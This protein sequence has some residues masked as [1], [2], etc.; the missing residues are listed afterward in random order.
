MTTKS[1]YKSRA[2][3]EKVMAL[4]DQVLSQWPV[5][6]EQIHVPTRHGD[7]FVVA[8]GK[9]AAPPMVLLHGS[10]SNSATWA[11]DVIEYSE[12]YRVYAVDI[13]GEP[14]KSAENRFSWDGPAFTEWLADVL[15][16]LGVD[17][18]ILVG[19]SLGGWAA[20]KYAIDQPDRVEE[21][22]LICPSG[23]HPPR[24]SFVVRAV[25]FSLLGDWGLNRMKRFV[26]QDAA[27]S[28]E[29][30]LFFTLVAKHFRYR[31]GAP[32]LFGDEELARLTMPVLFLAGEKDVLLDSQ[33]S[34]ERLQKTAPDVTVVLFQEDG[35]ATINKASQVV[36]FLNGAQDPVE[37]C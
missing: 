28:E 27:L 36:S 10:G 29:A 24:L 7:T 2:G 25:G 13:L 35:H 33:K 16:G 1:I 15:D 18:V 14:G 19:M 30:D 31:A 34:A 23:I 5:P 6:C 12:H 17:R 37:C 26:F 32:R 3:K 22:I 8:S 4:Y 9:A 11:H 20:M 21:A